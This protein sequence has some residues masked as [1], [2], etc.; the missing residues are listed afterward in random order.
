M[1]FETV[2]WNFEGFTKQEV[3]KAIPGRHL[4]GI[5]KEQSQKDFEGVVCAKMIPDFN[6]T[7]KDC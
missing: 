1:L 6:V 2:C 7:Y 5:L 3:E 4:Q